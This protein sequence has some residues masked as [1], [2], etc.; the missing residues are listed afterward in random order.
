MFGKTKEKNKDR[1]SPAEKKEFYKEMFSLAVP[2]GLQSLLVA[3]IGATDALMLGRFSQ[4]AVSAVSLANQIVFI[5][6]LFSSS[7]I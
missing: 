1:M 5:M 7:V 4:D 3:L 2:I 6:H